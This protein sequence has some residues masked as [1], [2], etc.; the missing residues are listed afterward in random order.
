M[1]RKFY[2]MSRQPFSLHLDPGVFFASQQY[3]SARTM[4]DY[5]VVRRDSVV[6]ITGETG[7]G[8]SMLIRSFRANLPQNLVL[9][10]VSNPATLE[11]STLYGVAQAF[12]LDPGMT[13]PALLHTTLQ[14]F[15]REQCEAGRAVMLIVDEAQTLSPPTL[16]A[17]RMLTN[18][19]ADH[20]GILQLTLVGQ[21]ELNRRIGEPQLESLK[22]RIVVHLHLKSLSE[23]ETIGYVIHRLRYAGTQKP[24]FTDAALAAVFSG[25][26]GVPRLINMI[27]DM[28]LLYGYAEELAQIDEAVIAQVIEDRGLTMDEPKNPSAEAL[29]AP[30]AALEGELV[31]RRE[32]KDRELARRVFG[33]SGQGQ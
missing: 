6:L 14:R 33:L 31:K 23:R 10:V 28:A 24:I 19:E 9:G 11:A 20:D 7:C 27:C 4:I 5:A 29:P 32:D 12:G 15:V 22:Q 21:P 17:L 18:P 13:E 1:Y 16:Q 2:G 8:K 25:S 30:E 26:G 3:A